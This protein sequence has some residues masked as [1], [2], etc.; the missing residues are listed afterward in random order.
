[1]KGRK[2]GRESE[3]GREGGEG[4]KKGR[5]SEEGREGEGGRGMEREGRR[6]RNR[7]VKWRKAQEEMSPTMSSMHELT[8]TKCHN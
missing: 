6:G 3:E 5:E 1:M 2:K 8:G 7:R 4:R